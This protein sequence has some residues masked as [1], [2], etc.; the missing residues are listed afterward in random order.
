MELGKQ[1][2]RVGFGVRSRRQLW[3]W[4]LAL[5]IIEKILSCKNC[6]GKSISLSFKSFTVGALKLGPLKFKGRSYVTK[7]LEPQGE[8]NPQNPLHVWPRRTMDKE[9]PP[10]GHSQE[11]GEQGTRNFL[12]EGVSKEP[13]PP[14]G[15]TV[16]HPHSLHGKIHNY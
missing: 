9:N 5:V 15:P 2:N 7:D 14:P 13:C 3:A 12:T 1:R 16:L 4:L 11:R 10:T 6:T 8:H